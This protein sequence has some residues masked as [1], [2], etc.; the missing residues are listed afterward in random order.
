[1]DAL[2]EED[3]IQYIWWLL[4][5]IGVG[6][7]LFC[8]FVSGVAAVIRAASAS[9]KRGTMILLY[10]SNVSSLASQLV[11]LIAWG[12]QFY[13][14][15]TKNVLLAEDLNNGWYTT[16]MAWFSTSYFYVIAGVLVAI[17]NIILLIAATSSASRYHR[18]VNTDNVDDKMQ[19]AIMLY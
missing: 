9:K 2:I 14:G 3:V 16:G 7:G 4:T 6:L 18:R 13:K 11:A 19:G 10:I 5:T 15:L 12:I 17:I 8:S 1:M